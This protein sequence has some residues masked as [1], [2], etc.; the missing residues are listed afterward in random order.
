MTAKVELQLGADLTRSVASAA[1][2]IADFRKWVRATVPQDAGDALVVIRI[3]SE[4]ES[5]FL[6]RRYRRKRG[7]TNVLSFP[8]QLAPDVDDPLLGDLVICAPVV[9][10]EAREQG[11][12]VR[13]HWAHMTVHGTLHLLGYDHV[14]KTDAAA[15]EALE[16]RVMNKLGFPDP[17][18]DQTNVTHN[19]RRRTN[20]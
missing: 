1:P 2:S 18:S 13:A 5:A 12:I 7:S 6:N 15:M 3:V 10:R 14:R 4:D 9:V 11:K 19:G 16:L 17:Y 20:P 8:A